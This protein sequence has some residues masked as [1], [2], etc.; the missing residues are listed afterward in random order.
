MSTTNKRIYNYCFCK[1]ILLIYQNDFIVYGGESFISE[2][3]KSQNWFC[4]WLSGTVRVCWWKGLR[5]IDSTIV[6]CPHL[7]VT[8]LWE[9]LFGTFTCMHICIHEFMINIIPCMHPQVT[10]IKRAGGIPW[11]NRMYSFASCLLPDCPYK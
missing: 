10:N 6:Q 1:K 8:M 9:Q 2:L 7:T 3:T 11:H 4:T 5:S